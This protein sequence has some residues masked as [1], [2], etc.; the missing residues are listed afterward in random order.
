MAWNDDVNN[1][2]ATDIELSATTTTWATRVRTFLRNAFLPAL[3]GMVAPILNAQASADEAQRIVGSKL[4]ADLSNFPR[5]SLTYGRLF[6][7]SGA[8]PTGEGGLY[9]RLNTNLRRI[10][11]VGIAEQDTRGSVIS[12]DNSYTSFTAFPTQ[13][14]ANADN[15]RAALLT[16]FARAENDIPNDAVICG[17][18]I[19]QSGLSSSNAFSVRW[20]YRTFS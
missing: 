9:L 14:G 15:L 2:D 10:D 6:G 3:K 19:S 20:R 13:D 5:T 18:D 8:V 17:L 7:R 1:L 12:G 4:N 16:L 11:A